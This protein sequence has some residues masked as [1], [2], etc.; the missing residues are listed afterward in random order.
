MIVDARQKYY[1]VGV[2]IQ[3]KYEGIIKHSALVGAKVKI[4]K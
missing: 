2:N 1:F 4:K 3:M